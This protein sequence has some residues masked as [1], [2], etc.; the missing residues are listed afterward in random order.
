MPQSETAGRG[1]RC[2]ALIGPYAAGKTTLLESLLMATGAIGRKGSVVQGNSVG[3]ATPE[4]REHGMS[5]ELNVATAT[6]LDDRF[7]FLDCP[8]SIE[9]FQETANALTG[10]DAAVV[11]CEPE[12]A[13]AP[14]LR[15]YLK[16][17]EDAGIPHLLFVNKIDRASGNVHDLLEALQSA[18]ARPLVLRQV[19]ITEGETI[20]GYVDLA[21]ERAYAYRPNDASEIIDLPAVLAERKREARYQMLERL[22]DFDDHLMEELLEEVEPPREEVFKDLT[23]EFAEDQI[24][25]VLLG[26][27]ER[28][29]GVRRLLKALRHEVPSV[30]QTAT[31]LGIG[32]G[33]GL[34]A[35]VVKTS[36]TAHGGKLSIARILRGQVK[37]GD[38]VY[39]SEGM[40]GRV[41]GLYRL[42]GPSSEKIATAEAGDLVALGRLDMAQTGDSLSDS[43]T[44]T[45]P[46][47]RAEVL[48]PVYALALA[49]SDRKDEVKL[50]TAIAKICEEDPALLFEQS[51]DTHELLLRGQGEVH[52]KVAV[53]RLRHKY[54]LAVETRRPR[55]AYREAIRRPVSQRY[56]HKRQTG[57]HG[58]FADVALEI[59]P[60][61]RGA[62]F[63]FHDT[64][65]GGVVP[66]QYIPAVE[67][68]VRD[69]L[70]KGPLGFPIVDIAVTLTDGS[71][72][73]VDSSDM[74]FRIAG[75]QAMVEALP[76]CDPILLEPVMQVEICVPS[77]AT[78]KVNAIISS[79]RG[80]IL[81]F[82]ARPGWAGWDAI[83]AYL[84]QVELHDLIVD[85][86]SATQGVGSFT[87]RYDHLAELTG[88]AADQ[89]RAAVS[90]A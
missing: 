42:L 84:P 79:R 30:A 23:L 6:H 34:L 60:L 5:T 25:P 90:A 47:P 59:A 7:A 29:H 58:Q 14:M 61:P 13:K 78:P 20:T 41:A 32:D 28:D 11:V 9:F 77:E 51:A 49:T 81:G 1:P 48:P 69:A 33:A 82:D 54:G 72:H 68:G 46:L 89:A 62:G 12:T 66:K 39:T 85:L 8:G 38:T 27:A 71:Y 22:A 83:S 37:E 24:V 55:I 10:V 2:V 73:S 15:P 76:K 67:A 80:Q 26:A 56:R 64:I 40:D 19:P 87:W 16:H 65:T 52:L 36:H 4:A 74:A 45:E 21:S 3:D 75:R 57:G 17:L 18:S 35:Q 63:A 88:K 50:T 70:D 86:R 43:K 53:A 44:D 31:R